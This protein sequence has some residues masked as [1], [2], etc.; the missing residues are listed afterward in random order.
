MTYLWHQGI[1]VEQDAVIETACDLLRRET[2]RRVDKF[3]MAKLIIMKYGERLDEMS[4]GK[5]EVD[6]I[7]KR[8]N[9]PKT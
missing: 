5:V 4:R 2:G 1:D 7:I 3:T 6:G 9:T 8:E